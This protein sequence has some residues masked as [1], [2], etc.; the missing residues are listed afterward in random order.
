[1]P[2]KGKR[3]AGSSALRMP[4]SGAAVVRDQAG[5]CGRRRVDAVE[6]DPARVWASH[7]FALL[8]RTMSG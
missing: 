8:P 6:D 1:M 4:V 7:P 3:T 5:R 2:E